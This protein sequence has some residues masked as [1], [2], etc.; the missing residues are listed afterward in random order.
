[1]GRG[2]EGD[3]TGDDIGDEVGVVKGEAFLTSSSCSFAFNFWAILA[4]PN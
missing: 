3:V 1:M 4:P 2:L